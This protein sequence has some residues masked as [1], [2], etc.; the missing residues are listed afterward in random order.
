MCTVGNTDLLNQLTLEPRQ[1]K[2]SFQGLWDSQMAREQQQ[3]EDR[4][5]LGQG[6]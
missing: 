6:S 1:Q 2:D 5:C 3:I 4:V